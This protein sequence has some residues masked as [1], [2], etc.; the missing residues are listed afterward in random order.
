[1]SDKTL[2]GVVL[3]DGASFDAEDSTVSA[4]Y[5]MPYA[6]DDYFEYIKK[7]RKLIRGNATTAAEAFGRTESALDIGHAYGQNIVIGWNDAPTLPLSPVYVQ[8][9][10]IEGAF[11]AD[12]VSY[13][14]GPEGMVVS[15][16]LLLLGVSGWYGTSAPSTSWLRLP[17]PPTGLQQVSAGTV[18]T[19]VKA[20]SVPL[21][22][23][24]NYRS[25]GWLAGAMPTG[26]VDSFALSRGGQSLIGPTL[27]LQ[28]DT[29]A[30]G[31]LLIAREFEYSLVLEPEVAAI[32]TGPI[33]EEPPPIPLASIAYSQSSVYTGNTSATVAN[34][35]DDNVGGTATGTNDGTLE[36]I[37]MDLGAIYNVN[38]VVIGTATTAMPGGWSKSYTE[39]RDIQYSTN[40]TT[41]TVG[42]NTGTFAAEGVYELAVN[43]SARY[44]RIVAE[45]DYLA[46]TEL[47]PLALDQVK[48]ND[49]GLFTGPYV[50]GLIFVPGEPLIISGTAA[51]VLGDELVT[52]TSVAT[53]D[54][55]TLAY[56]DLADEDDVEVAGFGFNFTLNSVAYTGCFAV[57]NGYLTFGQSSVVYIGLGASTPA[58]PKLHFNSLDG[59]FQRVYT[60]AETGLFRIRWEG[61]S[62]YNASGS[63]RFVEITFYAPLSNGS[64]VLEVRSGDVFGSLAG[65]FMLANASTAYASGAFAANQS[66]IFTGNA[67]GTSWTLQAGVHAEIPET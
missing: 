55:W 62:I 7:I 49:T 63:S 56:D 15:S 18:G 47:Y 58:V 32:A 27:T 20:N 33:A 38:R 10:G 54:G 19:G 66:W 51:P 4:E 48:V 9:A 14:W 17:V 61:S 44:I 16:D 36:W 59:S 21:P 30:T 50:S 26:G 42:G 8:L 11:L 41:W 39:N 28:R 43:F 40:G 6:P 45:N 67:A 35:Q 13:A 31:P 34:M 57:S 5:D 46:L 24:F 37:A 25:P 1:M 53:D 60:K 12:S 52:P 22:A 2:E 64:Q 23:D 3:F 65:P 29:I